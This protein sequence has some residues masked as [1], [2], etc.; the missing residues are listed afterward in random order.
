MIHKKR[1]PLDHAVTEGFEV[2]VRVK[3]KGQ[4]VMVLVKP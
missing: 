4:Q 1:R 3:D 2:S